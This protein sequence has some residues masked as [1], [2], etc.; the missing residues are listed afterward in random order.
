MIS[1]ERFRQYG[2]MS[3][4][5]RT[6]RMPKLTAMNHPFQISMALLVITCIF[7]TGCG[8]GIASS[9]RRTSANNG[10]YGV[11]I[12][13][14]EDRI[15]PQ[16]EGYRIIVVEGQ[17]LSTETIRQ[18]QDN[19]HQVYSYLNIGSLETYRDYYDQFAY[20]VLD[21][22]DNWPDEYWIDATAPEW[23]EYIVDTVGKALADKKVDGFFLDNADVYYQYHHDGIY[24]GLVSILEGLQKYHLKTIINGGDV[25]VSRLLDGGSTELI[26]G[27]NQECVFSTIED[28]SGNI[29]GAQK[30]EDLLYFADYLDMVRTAG[31]EV[32]LLEYTTDKKLIERI[33]TFCKAHG[34]LYYISDSTALDGE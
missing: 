1:T 25:F 32:Y 14:A 3:M 12:G 17:E 16:A 29:F 27:I 19:G 31:I 30:K 28:Y 34:Y 20:A 23:R 18:L 5:E 6:D 4:R 11:L 33:R 26:D 8:R 7:L 10:D 2:E 9:M 24:D 22:Y 13:V 15:I 21:E